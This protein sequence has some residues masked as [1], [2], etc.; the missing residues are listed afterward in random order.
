MKIAA[1][2]ND[3]S[4]I[5]AD[6]RRAAY[7]AVLTVE[8][9]QIVGRELRQKQPQGWYRAIGHTEHHGPAGAV[10]EV[11]HRH[12]LLADPIRDC[13]AALVAGIDPVD[14]G[15]LEEIDVWPVVVEPGPIDVAVRA[16]VAG[17]LVGE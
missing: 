13:Q 15:H 14:R 17:T 11:A 9:G 10:P 6:F 4:T 16:F 2:T 8:G 12:D 5:A 7:Y 1:A 3:G